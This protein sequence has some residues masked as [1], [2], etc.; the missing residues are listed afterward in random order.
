MYQIIALVLVFQTVPEY[1]DSLSRLSRED[2]W[3]EAFFLASEALA[4]GIL[5]SDAVKEE[6]LLA[7]SLL[8]ELPFMH[9]YWLDMTFQTML[10]DSQ[11]ADSVMKLWTETCPGSSPAW[12]SRARRAEEDSLWAEVL[13]FSSRG[14]GAFPVWDLQGMPEPRRSLYMAP[15][16]NHLTR[17]RA[18]A[19]HMLG[20]SAGAMELLG[21]LLRRDLY[22][23]TYYHS[24]APYY[25]LA[26]EITGNAACLR[27]AAEAGDLNNEYASEAEKLLRLGFGEV[28]MDSARAGYTGPVFTEETESLLGVEPVPSVRHCWI[29]LNNDGR[30]DLIA[31]DR[32]YINHGDSLVHAGSLGHP[33]NGGLA[34]DLN[35]DGLDDL[36]TGGHLPAIW[37]RNPD[38]L[39][40]THVDVPAREGPVEGIATG[41]LTGNGFPD[42]VLAVYETPGE[43]G[44]GN[45]DVL[46]LNGN[47]MD[48]TFTELPLPDSVEPGCGRDADILDMNGDGRP[49][50]FI[51][52]YRDRPDH[53]WL[54]AGDRRWEFIEF[55][56]G[57]TGNTIGTAF[58]DYDLDGDVDMFSARLAHPRD[59]PGMNRSVLL[60]NSHGVYTDAAAESGIRYEETHACPVWA[61]FNTDGFPDL[62]ITSAYENRRSFLYMNNGDGTFTD[63]TWLS[64]TRVLDGW[65]VTAPDINDDGRP[66]LSVNAGG[67]LRLFINRSVN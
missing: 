19:L 17:M 49:D 50:I 15:V 43:T 22:P 59:L 6:P 9:P 31:G 14:L 23:L 53:L 4:G 13:Q 16:E 37:L 21:P 48:F 2:P 46:I 56:Q 7:G 62:Y 8:T 25:L 66:D 45:P 30:P 26:G 55:T 67:I 20:D 11:S 27:A 1:C 35:L 28:Y 5:R 60:V 47:G 54:N 38:S 32:M 36:V 33:V 34:R 40:F 3:S 41:D 51:S 61:D 24:P 44:R 10:A 57:G 65:H 52:N 18:K 58:E 12:L 39:S 29:H 64:G 63:V 42:I